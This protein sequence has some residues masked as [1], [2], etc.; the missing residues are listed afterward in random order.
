MFGSVGLNV[1]A[2]LF[3]IIL[4]SIDLHELAH[5][6]AAH[7]LGDDTPAR[8]GQLSLNPFVHMDQVGVVVLLVSSFLGYGLAWGRTFV[9]PNNLKFGP[10]R[11]GA[12][13]AAAGPLTNLAI[14]VALAIALR[15]VE[16]SGCNVSFNVV[17]FMALALYVNIMLF[18]FN[19]IPLPPLDGFTILS[20][21]LT[22]RQLYAL[23]PIRQYGP[24]L[25]LF[26]VIGLTYLNSG[27]SN[28]IISTVNRIESVLVPGYPVLC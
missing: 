10:Q 21:F 7:W 8:S 17:S 28:P 11:G 26:L 9:Q 18:V 23:A 27:G 2:Q 5:G 24:M 25:L 20:G 6:F 14:A 4:L 3:V 16:S 1:A 19:L 13:V 12:I 22:T 15:V